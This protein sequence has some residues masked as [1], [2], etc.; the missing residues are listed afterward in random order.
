MERIIKIGSRT[1]GDGSPVFIIAE[2][3]V[4]HN[5][6]LEIAQ[7]LV[8]EAANC[9]A[10]CV[11]FQTFKAERVVTQKAPKAKYQLETTDRTE[12]QIDMLRKIELKPEHHVKL[13]KY[14]EKLGMIFLSTPYSFEDVDFLE[15]IG[16]LA[17]KVASGQ[18]V[19][20]AFLCKIAK[21]GKPLF[22]STG[23]ATLGEIDA[24]L[25]A[26][27]KAGNDK[28]IL[29][30]CTTNYPSRIEDAN[31]KVIQNLK[32]IFGCLV[33][34]SDHTI[35]D[36]AAI[37]AVALGANV[38]EKHFTL[39]KNL[40]GPDHSTSITPI[41][42]RSFAEKIHKIETALGKGYKEPTALEKENAINMRRSITASRDI[43]KDEI[44]T[45]DKITFKRP[46][47]GLPP[48]FYDMIIG[49][50][51]ARDILADELLQMDMI[52]W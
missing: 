11:K 39:D 20:H 52:K 45:E 40:P 51:A 23:M 44:I 7:R 6:S 38:I 48:Q 29:L 2:A 30:Q 22:L 49:K 21:T 15:S 16:V 34:Y 42:L 12:S 13:K 4:N 32:S 41:E 1:I 24:A 18:I 10:D 5:G 37:T 46:A 28:V 31:L 43:R 26:V 3:G 47:T 25:T 35:G 33:G 27:L 19:E 8:E 14:A 50:K 17:Y 36:E 9:G